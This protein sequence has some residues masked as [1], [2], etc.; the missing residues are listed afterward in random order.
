VF[1]T[2][3]F[4]VALDPAFTAPKLTVVGLSKIGAADELPIRLINSSESVASL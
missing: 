1:V 4:D 3:T 2:V